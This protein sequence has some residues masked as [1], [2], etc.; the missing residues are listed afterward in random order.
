MNKLFL[1]LTVL[2]LVGLAAC[3]AP[4]TP[5]PQDGTLTLNLTGFPAADGG[6]PVV[7]VLDNGLNVVGQTLSSAAVVSG[8][9]S[10]TVVY[11][12]TGTAPWTGTGGTKY[13]VL[14]GVD[15]NGNGMPVDAGDFLH[16]DNVPVM[17]FI[18]VTING[19]RVITCTAADFTQQ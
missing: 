17:G 9:A 14:I 10:S 5:A 13:Y 18:N 4:T 11:D 8:G 19:N 6:C 2:C 16:N 12:M 1:F 7:W 15:C 3:P